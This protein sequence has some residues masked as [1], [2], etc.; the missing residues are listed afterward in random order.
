[1]TAQPLVTNKSTGKKVKNKGKFKL[2]MN[3]HSY[4]CRGLAGEDRVIELE[5]ALQKIKWGIVGLSEVRKE[6]ENLVKRKN[7]NYFYYFGETKGQKGIGFYVR[8]DIWNKVYEIKGIN[9]RI[10]LIKIDYGMKWKMTIIQ[11]YAPI[12]DA[13]ESDKDCF[14]DT[15]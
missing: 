8:G 11:V 9:E 7:G 4:N 12:L 14:Y 2:E 10:G 3:L 5:N 6:G 13:N 1:M 15:L